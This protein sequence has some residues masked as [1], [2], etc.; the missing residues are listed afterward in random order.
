MGLR[1]WQFFEPLLSLQELF[2]ETLQSLRRLLETLVV[3]KPTRTWYCLEV[4]EK[5]PL[6]VGALVS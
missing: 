2:R 5:E 4:G 3:E 6:R 1:V